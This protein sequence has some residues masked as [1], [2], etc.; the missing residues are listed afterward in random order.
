MT[1]LSMSTVSLGT[2]LAPEL[3]RCNPETAAQIELNQ[4]QEGAVPLL[5]LPQTQVS[6]LEHV[7]H[8]VSLGVGC[9]SGGGHG[10]VG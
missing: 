8:V 2:P 9:V 4:I 10:W 7:R 6:D 5:F 1:L 3:A